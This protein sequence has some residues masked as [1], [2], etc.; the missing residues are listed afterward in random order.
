MFEALHR[1]THACSAVV[2]LEVLIFFIYPSIVIM[3][4]SC[5]HPIDRFPYDMHRSDRVFLSTLSPA[6]GNTILIKRSIA[7]D[8]YPDSAGRDYWDSL[9]MK[10]SLRN[11]VAAIRFVKQHTTVPVPNVVGAFVDRGVYYMMIEK[12][13]NVIGLQDLA[14]GQREEAV[15]EINGY[16]AQLQSLR[17]TRFGGVEGDTIIP[18]PLTASNPVAFAHLDFPL[19]SQS[20]Y[21]LCHGDLHAGNILLDAETHKVRCIVD[22]EYA[23]F[24]PAE[25]EQKWFLRDGGPFAFSEE[26]GQREEMIDVVLGC[27]TTESVERY[28]AVLEEYTKQAGRGEAREARNKDVPE[29]PL[30]IIV[31]F[32][33]LSAHIPQLALSPPR[34]STT[35]T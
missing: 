2:P 15:A 20:E 8:E 35:P 26:E 9:K 31:I 5:P 29:Y 25:M 14:P 6:L 11:E 13:Q 16:V 34:S 18:A 23:G 30:V 27:A 22:W 21:V 12:E 17:S 1:H 32:I 19:E 4:N 3:A 24:Y 33:H 10:E 28:R 7:P